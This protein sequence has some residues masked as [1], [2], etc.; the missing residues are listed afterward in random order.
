MNPL[1]LGEQRLAARRKHGHPRCASQDILGEGR[2][3]P[4]HVIAIVEDDQHARAGKEGNETADRIVSDGRDSDGRR[5]RCWN[6]QWIIDGGQVDERNR[7][8]LSLEDP[9]GHG[10]RHDTL[11]DSAGTCDGDKTASRDLAQDSL[12]CLIPTDDSAQGGKEGTWQT[13]GGSRFGCGRFRIDPTYG[14]NEAISSSAVVDYVP[15]AIS[16]VAEHLAQGRDVNP[17]IAFLDQAS[18]PHPG[19]EVALG[20]RPTGMVDE[21]KEDLCRAATYAERFARLQQQLGI[22]EQLKRAKRQHLLVRC[23]FG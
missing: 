23:G 6:Q 3:L 2:D 11:S 16:S 15:R 18:R 13:A 14:F 20:D 5:E 17:E 8:E 19:H 4:D 12:D 21:L 7:L 22:H 10:Q 9:L 1:S